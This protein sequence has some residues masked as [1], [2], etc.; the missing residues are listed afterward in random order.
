M[1]HSDWQ[2]VNLYEQVD[3]F[4]CKPLQRRDGTLA[5]ASTTF[6]D[7]ENHWIVNFGGIRKYGYVKELE[8]FKYN[9]GENKLIKVN[10]EDKRNDIAA[11]GYPTVVFS[12]YENDICELLLFGGLYTIGI[13]GATLPFYLC[14]INFTDKNKIFFEISELTAASKSEGIN[15]SFPVNRCATVLR[16]WKNDK[17]EDKFILF[18]GMEFNAEDENQP[19]RY[20][21]DCWIITVDSE[22]NQY[23]SEEIPRGDQWPEV[24]MGALSTT[25]SNKLLIYGGKTLEGKYLN[26]L[27]S[28]NNSSSGW[29]WEKIVLNPTETDGNLLKA[30]WASFN[31]IQNDKYIIIFAGN[32]IDNQQLNSAD[33]WS[34]D[35]SN[36]ELK[37]LSQF[38]NSPAARLQHTG[39][40]FD[41]KNEK[42]ETISS[43]F[44]ISGEYSR[45]VILND[46][47]KLDFNDSSSLSGPAQ[48]DLF[49]DKSFPHNEISLYANP[50]YPSNHIIDQSPINI[51]WKT[52]EEIFVNRR[53]QLF[54]DNDELHRPSQGYSGNCYFICALGLLTKSPN[55]L[56]NLFINSSSDDRYYKIQFFNMFT[57]QWE[58]IEVD[59]YF[60]CEFNEEKQQYQPIF[61][62][63][64]E[65]EEKNSVSIWSMILEKAF[66]KY[67]NSYDGTSSGYMNESLQMLLGTGCEF[68]RLDDDEINEEKILEILKESKNLTG[69]SCKIDYSE[70]EK[71][72][73]LPTIFSN[74][75]LSE[76]VNPN[77]ERSQEKTLKRKLVPNHA[78]GILCVKQWQ[79]E[80]YFV[81]LFDPLGVNSKIP[82][83]ELW[84]S[85]S[86]F[87]KSFR[88][89][90][91]FTPRQSVFRHFFTPLDAPAVSIGLPSF[92]IN[93]PKFTEEKLMDPAVFI[94]I[95]QKISKKIFKK[96]Y[97]GIGFHVFGCSE[98]FFEKSSL[99]SQHSHFLPLLS[100]PLLSYLAS[101]KNFPLNSVSMHV[102]NILAFNHL[103]VVVD[104]SE[105]ILLDAN[106]LQSTE[107]LFSVSIQ[108]SFY[109]HSIPAVPASA[110]ALPSPSAL[111]SSFSEGTS[112]ISPFVSPYLWMLRVYACSQYLRM[113]AANSSTDHNTVVP[114]LSLSE[115]LIDPSMTCSFPV[116]GTSDIS[117]SLFKCQC[118]SRVLCLACYARFHHQ[119]S[120]SFVDVSTNAEESRYCLSSAPQENYL[121]SPCSFSSLSFDT[122]RSSDE[123]SEAFHCFGMK[124]FIEELI[125]KNLSDPQPGSEVIVI[126]SVSILQRLKVRYDGF[127]ST[128]DCANEYHSLHDPVLAQLFTKL[129][130]NKLSKINIELIPL[131]FSSEF[132]SQVKSLLIQYPIPVEKYPA[133]IELLLNK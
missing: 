117:Q 120:A 68:I 100:S 133:H 22:N 122:N 18:G 50:K 105:R 16:K 30:V 93:I 32:Y 103:L 108:S 73:K 85:F 90:S 102:S 23:F 74:E 36:W 92:F 54:E 94:T 5:H 130:L 57:S 60:P 129:L 69:A 65:N 41:H 86:D 19:R 132:L 104:C 82:G 35:T 91:F 101:S 56:K 114:L 7:G 128:L 76:L 97:T 124:Q 13:S 14:K 77:S 33:V 27:W 66:A 121:H 78:Y 99:V 64:A 109:Q 11:C 110:N 20:L 9:H 95:S 70:N 48:S 81:Q 62:R 31:A 71:E 79:N 43:L 49:I 112:L 2:K 47:W 107:K 67:F 118:C 131:E 87:L 61:C 6:F 42:N 113:A 29:I 3:E 123:A 89:I 106:H 127:R 63:P 39:V 4:S 12:N 115:L 44:I 96:T 58:V 111:L 15:N 51:F 10:V 53:I 119:H 34:I 72:E 28:L 45:D 17:N 25:I 84:I 40:S 98:N 55:V 26:D 83:G 1:L 88:N 21:N 80:N 126:L 46:V 116:S 38:K 125:R 59:H 75:E 24:R 37:L 8:L 52:P